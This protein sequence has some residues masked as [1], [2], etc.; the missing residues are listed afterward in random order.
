MQRELGEVRAEM[1][2]MRA[3]VRSLSRAYV[4][5]WSWVQNPVGDVPE[6]D[7][8]VKDHLRTGV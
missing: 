8:L 2:R 4:A 6:P 3:L 5:L 1:G 7:E